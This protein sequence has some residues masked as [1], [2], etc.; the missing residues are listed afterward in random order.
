LS[1]AIELCKWK[2][3]WRTTDLEWVLGGELQFLP[4][5]SLF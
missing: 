5:F 2:Q 1:N 4:S 3:L